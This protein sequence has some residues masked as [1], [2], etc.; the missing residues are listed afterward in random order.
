MA[1]RP[2][3]STVREALRVVASVDSIIATATAVGTDNDAS[4]EVVYAVEELID[5]ARELRPH[6]VEDVMGHLKVRYVGPAS[7]RAAEAAARI[8]GDD[9]TTQE[10]SR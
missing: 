3:T 2:E 7:E 9:D 1:D 8:H 6:Q 4:R 10:T 5:A